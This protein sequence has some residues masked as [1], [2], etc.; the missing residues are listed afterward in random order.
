MS[1]SNTPSNMPFVAL[2]INV[3]N[4]PHNGNHCLHNSS[5]CYSLV[6]PTCYVKFL[7]V[8]T[9]DLGCVLSLKAFFYSFAYIRKVSHAYEMANWYCRG[10]LVSMFLSKFILLSCCNNWLKQD[11]RIVVVFLFL[12]LN[13]ELACNP[14]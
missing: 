13:R 1:Y 10:Q 5:H 3:S 2:N 6:M 9:S 8:C 14:L 4:G 12:S 7:F 11:G